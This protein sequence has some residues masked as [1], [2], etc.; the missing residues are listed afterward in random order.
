M[1]K[2]LSLLLAV[3]CAFLLSSEANSSDSKPYIA[4]FANPGTKRLSG[5]DKV[6]PNFYVESTDWENLEPFL[7]D[8]KTKAGRRPLIIDIEC[9]GS[10]V[11]GMLVIEYSSFGRNQDDTASVGYVVKKI[12]TEFKG[13]DNLEVCLEACH[14]SVCWDRTLVNGA[15]V[16]SEDFHVDSATDLVPFPVYG[17]GNT[18]NVNNMIIIQR[19]LNIRP[20]FYDLRKAEAGKEPDI[21]EESSNAVVAAFRMLYFWGVFPR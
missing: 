2:L 4:V 3:S 12:M 21:S 6:K 9:H 7:K 13:K 16:E 15:Y 14:S 8:V 5:W 10:P 19:I 20:F 1:R 11:T 17:V 18:V